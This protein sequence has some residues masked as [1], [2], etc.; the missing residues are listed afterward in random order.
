[1]NLKKKIQF[2]FLIQKYLRIYLLLIILIK[3]S[4]HK[5]CIGIDL[6]TTYSCVGVWRNGGVEIIA[7]KEGNRTTPSCVS[8]SDKERLVGEAAKTQATLNPENT[9]Y[10]V[11]RI[12]GL[13]FSDENLQKDIKNFTYKVKKGIKNQAIIKA[14]YKN[15]N[16]I[17]FPEEI[18]AMI[19]AEMKEIAEDYVGEVIENAII[20]VPAYFNDSQ[21]QATKDA[22]KVAG[23]NVLRIINEPTAAAIAYG[24]DNSKEEKNILV[25]DLGG[26]TFDVTVLTIEEGVFEVRS[27]AG[28]THLGGEDFDQ[29]MIDYFKKIFKKKHQKDISKD[30]KAILKLKYACERAKRTLSSSTEAV[31]NVDALYD[32]I[33][34]YEKINRA[35]FENLC[36]DLFESTLDPVKRVIKDAEMNKKE[37]DEVVLIG[38]STRIP[39][40]RKQLQKF[41]N[42]KKLCKSINPDEAVAYGAAVQGAILSGVRNKNVND[43]LLLDV[44]PL[45]LGVET[46]GGIMTTIIERNTTIPVRKSHTFTT[47]LDNQP[48][49]TI[50]VFEGERQMTVDNNKLGEFN[51]IGIPPMPRGQPQVE[52]TYDIDSNGILSVYAQEKTTGNEEKL[53]V[54]NEK[55]RLTKEQIDALITDAEEFR[56]DDFKRRRA[57]EERNA[58]EGFTYSLRKTVNEERFKDKFTEDEKKIVFDAA[59]E[60]FSWIED[61]KDEIYEVYDAKKRHLESIV[62]PILQKVYSNFKGNYNV[63][64]E[65]NNMF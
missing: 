7:N 9:I 58:L 61:N 52:V 54:N 31:V 32:G 39:K 51:L 15:K 12:I 18:S 40:I 4:R 6:G 2:F 36:E 22:G 29:R 5:V 27:T 30:S 1:M 19:L 14:K 57:I 62:N 20:T 13:G 45:S 16:K 48:G 38:G 49:C 8:F 28:N 42:N 59:D 34:F 64:E 60:T 50:Q 24:L 17:F 11:K 26:G 63:Y 55:G 53:T 10:D 25:F 3:M 46:A 35:T 21:R 23:L 47:F 65:E 56:D 41:F 37:I 44:I 33:D 43:I